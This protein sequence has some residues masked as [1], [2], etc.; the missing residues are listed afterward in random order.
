V[1]GYHYTRPLEFEDLKQW[2]NTMQF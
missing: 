1:Q 2:I